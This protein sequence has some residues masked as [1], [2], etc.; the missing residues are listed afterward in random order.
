[1]SLFNPFC[2]SLILFYFLLNLFVSFPDLAKKFIL[3]YCTAL[4]LSFIFKSQSLCFDSLELFVKCSCFSA[5]LVLTNKIVDLVF[6][7]VKS[8]IYSRSL[9]FNFTKLFLGSISELSRLFKL[10]R[11]NSKLIF[12]RLYQS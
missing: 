6:D 4:L 1:M 10:L 11:I 3:I 2:L 5:L 8:L 12:R 7:V 9:A